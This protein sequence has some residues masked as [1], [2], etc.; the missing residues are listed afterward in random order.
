MAKRLGVSTHSSVLQP[1]ILNQWRQICQSGYYDDPTWID[2]LLIVSINSFPGAVSIA[3][4]EDG[5][6]AVHGGN[7]QVPE[8]LLQESKANLLRAQVNRLPE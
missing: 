4:A 7:R 2:F 8:M 6:W 3:G 5:L 1:I